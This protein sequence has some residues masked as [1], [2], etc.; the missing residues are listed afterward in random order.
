MIFQRG[1]CETPNPVSSD[2]AN[3]L[4]TCGPEERGDRQAG[5]EL[6]QD[7]PADDSPEPAQPAALWLVEGPETSGSDGR[8]E[9]GPAPTAGLQAAA[10][11][12]LD[13]MQFGKVLGRDER[14]RLTARLNVLISGGWTV[15][16]L[17]EK[18][19]NGAKSP[20]AVYTTWLAG[21]PD[22]AP[23]VP[24]PKRAPRPADAF[25]MI[26]AQVAK[27][28]EKEP[29]EAE[30]QERRAA[31]KAQKAAPAVAGAMAGGA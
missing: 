1:V 23:T 16:A 31:L 7:T 28:R 21:L 25:S 26:D 19:L 17:T 10:A 30:D 2:P 8:T 22:T 6:T 4:P 14:A 24:A 15:K 13:R 9:T 11:Q 12:V 27:D 29:T 3:L 18:D 20:V 5:E